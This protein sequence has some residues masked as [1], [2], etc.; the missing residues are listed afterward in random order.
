MTILSSVRRIKKESG[1]VKLVAATK[2]QSIDDI[3]KVVKAGI[4]IIGES[5]IGEAKEKYT[6]LKDFFEENNVEFHFIGHLQRNKVKSAVPMFDMIQSLDSI[7]LAIKINKEAKKIDKTQSVLVQ[8]NIGREKQKYGI[9]PEKTLDFI[10][11]VKK[12][13]NIGLK[14]LMCLAPYF[15][16]EEKARPLFKEMKKLFDQTNLE[17]LS[18]GMTNDYRIAIEEGSN[19]IRTGRGIFGERKN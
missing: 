9:E 17:V 15:N 8:V 2:K 16:N 1:N 10:R 18:M 7:R 4:K 14:G 6:K 3:K 19:M 13:E 12:L 11:K 5:R